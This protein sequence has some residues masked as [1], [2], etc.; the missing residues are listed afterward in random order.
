MGDWLLGRWVPRWLGGWHGEG[1][2]K[3][4]KQLGWLGGWQGGADT[5]PKREKTQLHTQIMAMAPN[6]Q[7]H[8]ETKSEA[9]SRLTNKGS[10]GS[11]EKRRYERIVHFHL[12]EE[13]EV[14]DG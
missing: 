9:V 1:Q 14:R 10:H 7:V 13:A 5:L 11:S 6:M 12:G 2:V 4:D 8:K 3:N